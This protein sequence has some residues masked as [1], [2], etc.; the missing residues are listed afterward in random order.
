M[1]MSKTRQVLDYLDSA[2]VAAQAPKAWNLWWVSEDGQSDLH[3]GEY[4][5][6]AEAEAAVPGAIA[7][8][9]GQCATDIERQSILAGSMSVEMSTEPASGRTA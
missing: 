6:K 3:M 4:A 7:E 8:M 1:A 9:L 2:M 5:S